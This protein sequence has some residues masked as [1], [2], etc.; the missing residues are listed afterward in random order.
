NYIAQYDLQR[1]RFTIHPTAV[2]MTVPDEDGRPV[3]GPEL[4]RRVIERVNQIPELTGLT[5]RQVFT[6]VLHECLKDGQL[7]PEEKDL[8]FG[9]KQ[10]LRISS[11]AHQQAFKEVEEQLKG[12]ARS[13]EPAAPEEI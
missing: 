9:V 2:E 1:H 10:L 5:G 3:P 12:Q 6:T 8:I 4:A 7:T 13:T 11:Q